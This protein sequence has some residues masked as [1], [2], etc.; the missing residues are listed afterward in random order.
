[1]S[2]NTSDSPGNYERSVRGREGLVVTR[3][4]RYD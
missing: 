3:F 2:I 4:D 1:M